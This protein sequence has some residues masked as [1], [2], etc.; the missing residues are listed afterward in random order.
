MENSAIDCRTGRDEIL[1]DYTGVDLDDLLTRVTHP[2]LSSVLTGLVGRSRRTQDAAA[3]FDS[4]PHPGSGG[5]GNG[6][7]W[8]PAQ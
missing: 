7:P 3:Y 1:P 8:L 2:V 5:G 4:D 6:V